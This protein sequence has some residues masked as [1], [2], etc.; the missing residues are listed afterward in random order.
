VSAEII[1]LGYG[2][3]S[4]ALGAW[5]SG[6]TMI[7]C[8]PSACLPRLL[9]G[10]GERR[11]R[12]LLLTHIHFD[13]AGAAGALIERWPDLQVYV[14]PR[15]AAHLIDP[16]RLLASARQV[17]GERFD[18]LLG[19]VVAVPEKNLHTIEDGE[20]I[21]GFRAAWTPGHAKH[22]VAFLDEES[23]QAYCGDVAGVRLAPG[24]VIPPTPPPDIDLAAW[25]Q[26]LEI[27]EGWQPQS[28]ALAHYGL[29]AD[30]D[31][32]LAE[33]REALDRHEGWAR[34]GEEVFVERLSE[35]LR[36]RV[37][38]SEAE[39]YD[40]TALARPSAAGMRRWL[41]REQAAQEAAPRAP[42]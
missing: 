23:G 17:F 26:S 31:L 11:P 21:E 36:A 2:G 32:H 5:L 25:R 16:S 38:A 7:D 13:H 18:S 22:H 42:A 24:V 6:E 28:L 34:E 37:G 1:D 4:G 29:V 12:V 27:I 30:P 41:E 19:E 39:D 3:R 14:H 40:F 9:E 33:L 35:Y 10:L 15:G 8:G 20:L